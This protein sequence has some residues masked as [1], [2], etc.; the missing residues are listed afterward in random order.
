MQKSLILSVFMILATTGLA[1]VPV[2]LAPEV[3]QEKGC[4][5]FCLD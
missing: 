2:Q 5:V 4:L 1:K 3:A